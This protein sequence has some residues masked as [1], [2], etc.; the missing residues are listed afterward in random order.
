[1]S[2][3]KRSFESIGAAFGVAAKVAV[4]IV[5]GGLGA[6][7]GAVG[8]RWAAAKYMPADYASKAWLPP[9]L[10]V[11]GAFAGAALASMPLIKLRTKGGR[12][13]AFKAT[14]PLIAV[15]GTAVAAIATLG[16]MFWHKFRAAYPNV[17]LAL[18]PPPRLALNGGGGGFGTEGATGELSDYTASASTPEV[19][20]P[21]PAPL[22]S[23]TLAD[24]YTMRSG[25]LS[26]QQWNA[27]E[28]R[29]SGGLRASTTSR[30]RARGSVNAV[31]RPSQR[32]AG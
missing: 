24:A 28:A 19:L 5:V 8:F 29:R 3:R 9:V 16:P 2:D 21:P 30:R 13:K 17:A 6:A 27:I 1:M 14:L 26:P 32:W 12:E 15:G 25:G 23:F 20:P 31:N 11:G 10:G 4:P 18:V 22:A 7:V